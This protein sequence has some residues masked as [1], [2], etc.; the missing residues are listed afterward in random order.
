LRELYEKGVEKVPNSEA[1]LLNLAQFYLLY[2]ENYLRSYLVLQAFEKKAQKSF[3]TEILIDYL[4]KRVQERM[5]WK[6]SGSVSGQQTMIAGE[7]EANN[8]N[9]TAL[10]QN[11]ILFLQLKKLVHEQVAK[12]LKFWDLLENF[13]LNT[14]AI[15]TCCEEIDLVRGKIEKLWDNLSKINQKCMSHFLL[16]GLY[17]TLVN[18]TTKKGEKLLNDY[19]RMHGISYQDKDG[20]TNDNLYDSQ[21]VVVKISMRRDKVG[22]IE[23]CSGDVDSVFGYSGSDLVDS[24]VATL[25]STFFKERHHVFLMNH[26]E[27]GNEKVLNRLKRLHGYHH[28]GHIF[29]IF[30]WVSIYPNIEAGLSYMGIIRPRKVYNNYILL[31]A[32]GTVDSYSPEIAEYLGLESRKKYNILEICPTFEKIQ[33]AYNYI[34]KSRTPDLLDDAVEYRAENSGARKSNEYQVKVSHIESDKD[35][36]KQ[37]EEAPLNPPSMLGG[38]EFEGASNNTAQ[39]KMLA[40]VDT[41]EDTGVLKS[42]ERAPG[43]KV[44]KAKQHQK[45]F[46]RLNTEDIEEYK[47]VFDQMSVNGAILGF[48]PQREKVDEASYKNYLC[49]VADEIYD[50]SLLR[51]ITLGRN[52]ENVELEKEI[53][54]AKNVKTESPNKDI[55]SYNNQVSS[56]KE[57]SFANSGEQEEIGIS[58]MPMLDD[59][60]LFRN[61]FENDIERKNSSNQSHNNN[62]GDH[63][64][65]IFSIVSYSPEVV[66]QPIQ[67]SSN[68]RG[69]SFTGAGANEPKLKETTTRNQTLQ[70]FTHQDQSGNSKEKEGFEE[71]ANDSKEFI[72]EMV[73]N[74]NFIERNEGS[75]T[76]GSTVSMRGGIISKFEAL[77]YKKE[78]GKTSNK[79]KSYYMIIGVCLV[80]AIVNTL[81]TNNNLNHGSKK[82]Q[83]VLAV[84]RRVDQLLEINYYTRIVD[85]YL[86]SY[87]DATRH[88]TDMGIA[89]FPDYCLGNIKTQATHLL[90]TNGDVMNDIEGLFK[91][92]QNKFFSKYVT[93]NYPSADMKLNNVLALNSFEAVDT[94]ALAALQ[95]TSQPLSSLTVTSDNIA[96]LL[97]NTMNEM[98]LE[99]MSGF[100][101]YQ[102]DLEDTL[103]NTK[104]V[105][106][107]IA[108]AVLSV[109]VLFVV[110]LVRDLSSTHQDKIRFWNSLVKLDTV[111]GLSH[112]KMLNIFKENLENSSNHS[113][114]KKALMDAKKFG[115]REVKANK[116]KDAQINGFK[117]LKGYRLKNR[118]Y[119]IIFPFLIVLLLILAYFII[120]AVS[121]AN[122]V[123]NKRVYMSEIIQ[124]ESYYQLNLI[125]LNGLYQYV[126]EGANTYLQ[127]SL[128]KGA[129]TANLAALSR[130]GDFVSSFKSRADFDPK[131]F[132]Q[133]DLCQTYLDNTER[134]SCVAAA[135]GLNT[136]GLMAILTYTKQTL[137]TV[138]DL[139][140]ESDGS[141]GDIVTAVSQD[142]LKKLESV[143]QYLSQGFYL[144]S[145]NLVN[146]EDREQDQFQINQVVILLVFLAILVILN[147]LMV[148]KGFRRLDGQKFDNMKILRVIPAPLILESKMIKTYLLKSFKDD[149]SSIT[150]KI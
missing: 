145:E 101:I 41:R 54:T 107:G 81:L 129:L 90:R 44:A 111:K 119:F 92:S 8:L 5:E 147:Y 10:V 2:L 104:A 126:A 142:N 28:D 144:L 109:Y 1:I 53:D 122:E 67:L 77:L 21:T 97:L 37:T 38:S 55:A 13:E 103:S 143:L 4:K 30:L 121:V 120:S 93:L 3:E 106:L 45:K 139:A 33:N 25:M 32:D 146:N 76:T 127:G 18:N 59:V 131:G 31:K 114:F 98:Y 108:I 40:T 36:V 12:Q 56:S 125:T 95:I 11:D 69:D 83:R 79:L 149:L 71:E 34:T 66:E 132:I 78:E 133:M 49:T 39:S 89:N 9:V 102:E 24:N 128:V 82:V 14:R 115:V 94:L 29:P 60:Q 47:K 110:I 27:T 123:D 88:V 46:R 20:I 99:M 61:P 73:L 138:M 70:A 74:N 140:V 136:H 16:F 96:Y 17:Q 134:G 57:H 148:W 50:H 43:G 87:I 22:M 58:S 75:T 42:K 124:A 117:R 26:F 80:M 105:T 35:L 65:A 68:R 141:T 63:K 116:A 130:L 112:K 62:Q 23:E 48:V 118:S 85:L 19:T 72:Q 7:Y 6:L 86:N 113:Q 135:N 84:G 91:D 64:N 100:K 137:D 15:E 51:I 52:D 150:N